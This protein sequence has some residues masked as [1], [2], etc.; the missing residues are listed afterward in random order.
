[1]ALALL[2][3]IGIIGAAEAATSSRTASKRI[4]NLQTMQPCAGSRLQA[5]CRPCSHE[6]LIDDSPWAPPGQRK[7][8][9][10][11]TAA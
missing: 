9:A 6:W 1:M 11:Q 5:G 7:T 8:G 10:L 4:T 2:C 3:A